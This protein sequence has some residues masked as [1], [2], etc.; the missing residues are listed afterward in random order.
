MHANHM[1]YASVMVN[2]Q[3]RNVPEDV[4]EVLARRAKAAGQSLQSYLLELL[5][6]QASRRTNAEILA[7]VN[8]R[9]A[10]NPED[11]TLTRE[12]INE[13]FRRDRESH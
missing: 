1:Q 3:I 5:P 12:E 7:E 2:V 4:H 9:K 10:A 6:A 8:A 11:Y 13:F